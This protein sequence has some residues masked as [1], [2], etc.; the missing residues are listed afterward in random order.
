M[1]GLKLDSFLEYTFLSDVRFSPDGARAAFVA[2]TADRDENA[3]RS[4]LWLYEEGTVRRLTGMDREG[5]YFWEDS[6][7]ILFPADRSASEK[8]R[9]EAGETFTAYYRIA[10]DG[11]EALPAFTLPLESGELRPLGDGR[12]FFTAKIDRACPDA[13]LESAEEAQKRRE[14][15]KEDADYAVLE[16]HPFWHNGGTYVSGE[17]TALFLYDPAEKE[18]RRLTDPDTDVEKAVF[19]DG[20]IYWLGQSW[21]DRPDLRSGLYAV[22]PDTGRQETLIEQGALFASGLEVMDREL[23]LLL[24]EGETYGYEETPSFY[25]VDPATGDQRLFFRND[26]SI[27]NSTGSDCRLGHGYSVRIRG[28]EIYALATVRDRCAL[29]RIRQGILEPVHG[30][31]GSV[32]CFDVS[33][34]GEILAVA[35]LDGKLQELYTFVP[36]G[37]K[38]VT[39]FN[40]K[41]LRERYVA[42]YE[43]MTIESGGE[44]VDGWVLK[45]F[46]FDPEGTYPA[47]LDIHGGPRTVYGEIFYHEMQYWAG[48]GYFV[49]FCNPVGSDGRGDAFADI[50][51]GYGDREYRNLMDFTDAVL[52]RYPQIDPERVAVTGGSYGGFMTNWIV[53][54]TDRFRCAA[55]QRSISNWLSFWGTSDI[56][57]FFGEH[58]MAAALA[59]DPEKMWEQSPLKYLSSFRTPTLIIH[60]DCDYRCPVSEG[61]QMFSALKSRGVPARMV[62]FHGEN[63]ELSRSGKPLHRVRRLREITDWFDRWTGED[64]SDGD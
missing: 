63:H 35:M 4:N 57:I 47:V 52:E 10:T 6:R 44:R 31:P 11:G 60:S 1:E 28:E 27:G 15:R 12:W 58:Q 36:G 43:R 53:G 61:Y 38:R 19:L 8:K 18:V 55:T 37:A 29:M 49:F 59:D 20:R 5:T 17:R 46:G 40:G 23:I 39:D 33:C 16:E 54:H 56:G 45:P 2:K 14:R 64:A 25:L 13:F 41:V 34:R 30:A 24:S 7:H 50:R 48:K 26:L 62:V 3:H 22:D 21:T 51:G 32:D 9:R 42:P